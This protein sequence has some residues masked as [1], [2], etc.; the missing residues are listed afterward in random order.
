MSFSKSEHGEVS[1]SSQISWYVKGEIGRSVIWRERIIH[2][3]TKSFTS[4]TS[5]GPMITDGVHG[6]LSPGYC[7]IRNTLEKHRH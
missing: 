1:T 7:S 3:F 6:T 4:P 2:A 5:I